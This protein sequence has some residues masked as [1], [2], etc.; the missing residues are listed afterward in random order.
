MEPSSLEFSFWDKAVHSFFEILA[1]RQ[2]PKGLQKFL[3]VGLAEQLLDLLRVGQQAVQ[4][5][6]CLTAKTGAD[7]TQVSA[8]Q[9]AAQLL[10]V[11]VKLFSRHFQEQLQLGRADLRKIRHDNPLHF[12]VKGCFVCRKD[13]QLG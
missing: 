10:R 8:F 13:F 9:L 6:A 12:S 3:K 4:L 1:E 7:R 5:L 2:L 11:D